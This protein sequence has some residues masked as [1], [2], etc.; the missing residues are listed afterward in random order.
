MTVSTRAMAQVRMA[1]VVA[2]TL[3]VAATCMAAD[4]LRIT[5]PTAFSNINSGANF[6]VLGNCPGARYKVGMEWKVKYPNV[7]RENYFEI[8][9][10]YLLGSST[11]AMT[12]P[13]ATTTTGAWQTALTAQQMGTFINGY[14]IEATALD[15]FNER[16]GNRDELPY[17]VVS[18]Q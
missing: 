3:A 16:T 15:E 8:G 10:P 4:F 9:T 6:S 17:Y 5:A 13:N 7:L 11:A 12:F 1:C 14:Y 2:G 18:G